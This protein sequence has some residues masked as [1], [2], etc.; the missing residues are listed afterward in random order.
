MYRRGALK[1]KMTSSVTDHLHPSSKPR[2]SIAA[3]AKCLARL[4][5]LPPKTFYGAPQV[6]RYSL[7]QGYVSVSQ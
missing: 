2:T 7:L 5:N 1:E 4:P 3:S 6:A